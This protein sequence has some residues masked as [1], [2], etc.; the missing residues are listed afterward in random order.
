M[1]P[2]A[3]AATVRDAAP[4]PP[5]ARGV[6]ASDATAELRRTVEAQRAEMERRRPNTR[7]GSSSP[8]TRRRPGSGN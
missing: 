2:D 1:V 4:P 6:V 3:L 8:G 5:P 7:P